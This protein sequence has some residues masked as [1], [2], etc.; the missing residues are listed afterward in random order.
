MLGDDQNQ[1][2]YREGICIS[3][4][5]LSNNI[6][7]NE[8][9]CCYSTSNGTNWK[10]VQSTRPRFVRRSSGRQASGTS[11]IVIYGELI[12]QPICFHA[13]S[14]FATSSAISRTGRSFIRPAM[15][16]GTT[17]STLPSATA[18]MPPPHSTSVLA[19]SA[20]SA[21]FVPATSRLCAS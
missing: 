11:A 10:V 7:S 4:E 18:H 3:N 2:S 6:L 1:I 12:T 13:A 14:S 21:S 8:I 19:A 15:G 17:A 16:S 9:Y 5:I 20:I